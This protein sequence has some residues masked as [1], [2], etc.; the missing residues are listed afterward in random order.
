M[1]CPKCNSEDVT[2]VTETKGKMHD[3]SCLQTI[4]RW[5]LIL[6]T[7]GLW[8]LVRKGRGKIKSTNYWL[9][10]NCSNKWPV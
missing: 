10:K 3:G 7:G 5:T 6:C 8:L 4:G 2:V 9:C 1:I